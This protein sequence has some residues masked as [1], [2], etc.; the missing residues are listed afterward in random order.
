MFDIYCLE[1]TNVMFVSTNFVL[2]HESFVYKP[3]RTVSI[4]PGEKSGL[5][6]IEGVTRPLRGHEFVS[7]KDV[8][9]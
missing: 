6:D 5:S 2:S 4:C 8:V 3:L 9:L 1:I 7:D